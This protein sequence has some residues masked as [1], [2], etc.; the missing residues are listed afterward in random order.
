MWQDQTLKQ[1]CAFEPM[2]A[3]SAPLQWGYDNTTSIDCHL[4]R[5]EHRTRQSTVLPVQAK[6]NKTGNQINVHLLGKQKL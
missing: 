6:A 3:D 4:P 1:V 5:Q 2:L